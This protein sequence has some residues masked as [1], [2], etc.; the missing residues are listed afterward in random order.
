MLVFVKADYINKKIVIFVKVLLMILT[1]Y[2]L[3]QSTFILPVK[4]WGK[5]S[6]KTDT[7][8]FADKDLQELY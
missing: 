1:F 8:K 5:Y 7:Y 2:K 3:Y 6:F 4:E